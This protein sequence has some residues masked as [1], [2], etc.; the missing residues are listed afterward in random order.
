MDDNKEIGLVYES[1]RESSAYVIKV[2]STPTGCEQ[3][4][5]TAVKNKIDALICNTKTFNDEGGLVALT[6]LKNFIKDL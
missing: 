6:T 3:D 4:P 1:L 5:I 2:S